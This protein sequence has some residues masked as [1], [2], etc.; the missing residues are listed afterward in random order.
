V[1]AIRDSV[2][3]DRLENQRRSTDS[4][5]C[6]VNVGEAGMRVGSETITLGGHL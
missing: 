1:E 3:N 2:K 5:S 6:G 4:V